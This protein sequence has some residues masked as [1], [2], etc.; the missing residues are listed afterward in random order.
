VADS[1]STSR[2]ITPS[3]DPE[4]R[5]TAKLNTYSH[6]T[7]QPITAASFPLHTGKRGT[8]IR[9]CAP[10]KKERANFWKVLKRQNTGIFLKDA[11]RMT[12]TND[13]ATEVCR[14]RRPLENFW[15]FGLTQGAVIS[16]SFY[17]GSSF[18]V[19]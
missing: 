18:T 6:D 14:R 17:K 8:A 9:I 16:L 10:C 7:N 12:R 11:I 1:H 19:S 2:I 3:S 13:G 5:R 15:C 4:D